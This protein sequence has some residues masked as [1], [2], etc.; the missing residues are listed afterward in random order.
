MEMMVFQN[1]RGQTVVL[2]CPRKK[3]TS[4]HGPKL[5]SCSLQRERERKP[6]MER[7]QRKLAL[8]IVSFP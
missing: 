8:M 6:K 1:G 4:H 7:E 2:D 5:G 3:G